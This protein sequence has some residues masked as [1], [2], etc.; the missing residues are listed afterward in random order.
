MPTQLSE[1]LRRTEYDA[2]RLDIYRQA[3]RDLAASSSG[4]ERYVVNLL[5][6]DLIGSLALAI[7]PFKQFRNLPV[8]VATLEMG[9]PIVREQTPVTVKRTPRMEYW[10]YV[11]VSKSYKNN[12]QGPLFSYVYTGPTRSVL[13]GTANRG[14]QLPVYGLIRDTTRTTRPGGVTMGE[15]ELFIPRVS[16]TSRRVSWK[17]NDQIVYNSIGTGQRSSLEG[18]VQT[19]VT[20]PEL[21]C[22]NAE[23]Q[24]LLPLCRARASARI[25]EHVHAMV[26]EVQPSYSRDRAFYQIAE[27]RDLPRTVRGTLE[28]WRDFERAVGSEYFRKLL[29]GARYWR[30][31]H[32]L[33]SYSRTLGRN[34]GFEYVDS[35]NL[36][37][38]ASAAYLTFKFGWE[39][40]VRGIL[41]FVPSPAR[42]ARDVNRLIDRIGR[43]DSFRTSKTWFEKD[44]SAPLSSVRLLRYESSGDSTI[45]KNGHRKVELR[46]VANFHLHFPRLD[47]PRL[48]REL[49]LSR[50]GVYPTPTDLYNLIPWSWL[51]D[52]FTGVGDYVKLLDQATRERSTVNYGFI[53]YVEESEVTVG[54]F[55]R[56]EGS[57]RRTFDG[58]T[59]LYNTSSMYPHQAK[60]FLKYQLRK[61]LANVTDVRSYWDSDLS[62]EQSAIIGALLTLNGRY[63]TPHIAGS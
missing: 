32:L 14:E 31:P 20:G 16:S 3:A 46:V 10:S 11:S 24:T 52:W 8:D 38:M 57:V 13:S 45:R 15:F 28:V 7:D 23:V 48:R 54:Y 26:A 62:P 56:L 30:D 27:L 43:N 12:P 61:S 40:T 21:N 47:R 34:N 39:S 1:N 35:K 33:R 9:S 49:L 53:T 42:V 17:E 55:G 5:G 59:T 18:F 4:L 29:Q 44:A 2:H 25:A 41:Q 60:F 58:T 19:D 63:T 36:G 51:I 50:L 6:P 37:E 22:S